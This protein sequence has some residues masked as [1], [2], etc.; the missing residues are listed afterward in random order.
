MEIDD[1]RVFLAL[2]EH[3]TFLSAAESLGL[4]R[5]TLRARLES[6]EAEV[7]AP[8]FVRARS[9]AVP[10]A[11]ALALVPEARAVVDRVRSM[12]GVVQAAREEPRGTVHLRLPVGMPPELMGLF[13]SEVFRRYPEVRLTSSI[14]DDPIAHLP[15]DVDVILHFGPRLPRGAF[16]TSVILRV[17]ERLFASPGYLSARGRPR[18][19]DDLAAHTL[20]SWIPPGEDGRTWPLRSGALLSVSPVLCCPDIHLVRTLV[21]QGAGIALLPHAD[22][23]TSAVDDGLEVVLPDVVERECA[24]HLVVPEARA[25]YARTRSAVQIVQ[26]IVG[27]A[28]SLR[29]D[30]PSGG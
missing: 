11:A 26:E 8:L 9:G 10:T 21:A 1:L 20:L 6:L 15:D 25:A 19:V 13:V 17:R 3:G 22:L 2:V 28:V 5:S 27:G 14:A 29:G 7:G 16:R 30:E 24:L 23:P 18:S 12:S 4:A